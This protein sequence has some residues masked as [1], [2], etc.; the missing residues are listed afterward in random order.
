MESIGQKRLE[1][2]KKKKTLRDNTQGGDYN[3]VVH[4]EV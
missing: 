2:K 1:F 3:E 4:F